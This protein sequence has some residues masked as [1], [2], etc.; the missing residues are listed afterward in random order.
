MPQ[1]WSLPIELYFY[2]LIPFILNR[3]KILITLIALSIGFRLISIFFYGNNDPWSYRFFPSELIFFIL[4]KFT[5]DFY[6]YLRRREF[7][8]KLELLDSKLRLAAVPFVCY[9]LFLIY[10]REYGLLPSSI[11]SSTFATSFRPVTLF[12]LALCLTPVIFSLSRDLKFDRALGEL[13]YP[14]YLGHLSVIALFEAVDTVPSY[15]QI[16]I[17]STIIAIALS[18][19]TR[20]FERRLNAIFTRMLALT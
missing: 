12:I 2:L 19:V 14:I 16:L 10:Q 18:P 15:F 6:L 13:S 3:K 17:L 11:S 1:S 7:L 20:I 5:Y 8:Q 4:G 9:L